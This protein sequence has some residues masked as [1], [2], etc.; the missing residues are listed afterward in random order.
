MKTI[1]LH[2][3]NALLDEQGAARFLGTSQR[4]LQ[5]RRSQ[6]D[7]PPFLRLSAR[8][9]RYKRDDLAG[10]AESHRRTSTSG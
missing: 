9:V 2:D 4:F 7:G 8:C 10:W 3:P 5:K 1:S 6:G